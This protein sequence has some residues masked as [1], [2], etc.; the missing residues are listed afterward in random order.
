MAYIVN[1]ENKSFKVK[2]KEIGVAKYK[3]LFNDKEHIIDAHRTERD[4]F[5]VIIDGRSFEVDL[6]DKGEYYDVLINGNYFKV[7]ISDEKR[8]FLRNKGKRALVI[9]KQMI[10]APMPGK[11]I[12]ILVKVGERVKRGSGLI[13]IEAMKMEN[14]LKSPIDGKV[15]EINVEEGKAVD[16]GEKLVVVE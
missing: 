16:A 8:R 15:K 9:G 14:E 12:K 2:V 4:V 1:V 3:I 6:D 10:S 11:V 13:V 5:S 7:Y